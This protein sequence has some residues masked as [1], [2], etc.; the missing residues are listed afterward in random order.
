MDNDFGEN[1]DKV[2]LVAALI[3]KLPLED[4][5]ESV[6]RTETV[7]PFFHPSLYMEASG[8]GKLSKMK[9]MIEAAANFKA[10]IGKQLEGE[11]DEERLAEFSELFRK[12]NFD[13]EDLARMKRE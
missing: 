8:S 4:M 2:M 9:G 1:L 3:I 5:V 7:A 6:D 10:E 13:M 11:I 12:G